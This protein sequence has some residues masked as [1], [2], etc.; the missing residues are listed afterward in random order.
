MLIYV[1]PRAG[2]NKLLERFK[3]ESES[4][5]LEAG[6]IAFWGNGPDGPQTWWIGIEY[7]QLE[8]VVGCIKSGRFTG[9]QLPAMMRLY[10]ISYLLVEGIARPDNVSGQ[11]VRYRGRSVYGVGIRY[12]AFDNWLTSVA[13]FSALAGKP[14]TVKSAAT[15]FETIQ[16]IRD[17]YNLWQKPF[18][19]H[20]AISRPDLTKV[21]RISYDLEVI[22]VEP[23]DPDYPQYL[24]RKQLMQIKG[25]SWDQAG[26]FAAQ[27]KTMATALGVGQR[28]WEDFEGVGKTLAKRIYESMH[29]YPDP[30]YA[31]KRKR[32]IK[33][34]TS[35]KSDA[36]GGKDTCIPGI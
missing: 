4:M 5:M 6:D 2:S 17:A 9:T 15:E 20:N 12:S 26:R 8:D 34:E 13:V 19:E 33:D 18:D 10:D 36:V 24:L 21:E 7:K 25:I 29:G 31:T 1:D 11:L 3:G 32:R 30:E 16:M 35:L 27:F 23:G 28:E 14:C 22:K